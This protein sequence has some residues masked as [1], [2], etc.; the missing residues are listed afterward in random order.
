MYVK[1]KDVARDKNNLK[2]FDETS[3]KQSLKE[4]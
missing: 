1:I 4:F 3:R 2:E